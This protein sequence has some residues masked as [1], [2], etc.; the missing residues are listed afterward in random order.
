MKKLALLLMLL[1]WFAHAAPWPSQCPTGTLSSAIGCQPAAATPVATDLVLGWQV[2]QATPHTRAI[3]I[4]QIL[5]SALPAAFSTLSAAST[6]SGAGF[7]ARFASP[8]PIGSTIASTGAFTNLTASGTITL[9]TASRIISGAGL[10]QEIQT[11]GS[12]KSWSIGNTVDGLGTAFIVTT[13]PGANEAYAPNIMRAQFFTTPG[14]TYTLAGASDQ[15]P[16]NIFANYTGSTTSVT[17]SAYKFSIPTDTLNASGSLNGFAMF[18]NTMNTGSG[19]K[20]GRSISTNVLNINGAISGDASGQ[21]Y[22]VQNNWLNASVNVGGT[23]TGAGSK[24]SAYGSNPQVRLLSGATNW[25]LANAGGEIDLAVLAGA[26]VRDEIM[27]SMILE[28]DHAVA[29]TGANVGLA[30]G[31][32]TG[33][34]PTLTAALSVGGGDGGGTAFASAATIIAVT[35]QTACADQARACQFAPNLFTYGTDFALANFS[36]QS[37]YSYRAPGFSIDGSGQAILAK[38]LAVTANATGQLIDVPKTLLVTSVAVVVAGNSTGLGLNNYYPNDVI[39]GSGTPS[40]GQYKITNTQAVAATVVAGGTGGT[41]GACTI[42]GTTGTGTKVQATGVVSAGGILSGSLAISVAGNYTVNPDGVGKV[43]VGGALKQEPVTG[44]G[45]SGATINV[46]IGA[47]TI[48]VLAGDVYA[49]CP[50]VGGI[51][52]T[53]GSGAGLTLTP[54]CGTRD[55]ITIAAATTKLGVYGATP[56]AKAT[57]VGACAGNTGCQALRDALGNL[58]L[59]ATGSITN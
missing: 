22:G 27:L 17:A 45:L 3:Q 36:Q 57:P 32:Q 1:P 33:A 5:S 25:S 15:N 12:G 34:V 35:A 59:I 16:V 7:T 4:Q 14:A 23:N 55:G 43:V 49:V 2:S 31:T 24:G 13:T 20:G 21:Q 11:G 9:T 40:V 58:G 26:T 19:A 30:I 54:T 42:T 44:C 39:F 48:S 47:L 10:N 41:P 53:G 51:T 28:S 18:L 29:G 50:G 56:I 46:G 38:G 8:G 52:P 6:V 37:G